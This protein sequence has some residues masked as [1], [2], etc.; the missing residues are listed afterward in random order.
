MSGSN[1]TLVVQTIKVEWTK[2]ARGG[3]LATPRNSV[4]EIAPLPFQKS[5]LDL[6]LPL[7]IRHDLEW[8]EKN[9]FEKPLKENLEIADF[10]GTVK[11]RLLGFYSE[12]GAVRVGFEKSYTA[13]AQGNVFL[14]YTQLGAPARVIPIEVFTLKTEEWGQVRY[15]GRFSWN[16]GWKYEKW[17]YNIAVF[18]A[19]I[20]TDCFQGS[21][22]REF[23]NMADLR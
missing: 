21:P 23:S 15:N 19:K 10:S 13:K 12:G 17:V 14:N 18:T 4:Q 16:S 6:T 20:P 11:N 1:L 9:Q 5:P 3:L 22:T 8:G 7:Y 2:E